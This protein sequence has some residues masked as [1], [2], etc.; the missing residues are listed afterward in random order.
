MKGGQNIPGAGLT[1]EKL[2]GDVLAS[3]TMREASV[4]QEK[5]TN[6][7]PKEGLKIWCKNSAAKTT[8]QAQ[9]AQKFALNSNLSVRFIC[10]IPYRHHFLHTRHI[11]CLTYFIPHF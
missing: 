5:T 10:L 6:R 1:E 8:L 3:E 4:A 11:P 2:F 9:V 7:R